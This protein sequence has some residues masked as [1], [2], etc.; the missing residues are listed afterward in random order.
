MSI[1]NILIRPQMLE[2]RPGDEGAQAL[3]LLTGLMSRLIEDFARNGDASR[4]VFGALRAEALAFTAQFAPRLS[5]TREHV[6][7]WLRPYTDVLEAVAGLEANSAEDILPVVDKLLELAEVLLADLHSARIAERLNAL[8][9]VVET[10]LGIGTATFETFFTACFDRVSGDLA[11]DFLQGAQTDIA[12]NHFALSRQLLALRRMLR[13]F[14]ADAPIPAFNRR[15][16]IRDLQLQLAAGDWDKNLDQIR[17]KLTNGKT[18]LADLLPTLGDT[19]SLGGSR[20]SRRAR[21]VAEPGQYSWYGSWF[22]GD[23]QAVCDRFDLAPEPFI[24]DVRLDP[25]PLGF[26]EHWAHITFVLD[27]AARALL[28]GLQMENGNRITPALNMGWQ[29]GTGLSSLLA[30][31]VDGKEWAEYFKVKTHPGFRAGFDYG[32]TIAGSFEQW[33]GFR[34]WLWGTLMHDLGNLGAGSKWSIKAREFFLTL[35]T[36]INSESTGAQKNHEKIGGFTK[37][38]RMGGAYLGAVVIGRK[39]WYYGVFSGPFGISVLSI[40][41]GG[42]FAFAGEVIAWLL[43]GAVARRLS[44]RYW[45]FESDN[46]GDGVLEFLGDKNAFGSFLLWSYIEFYTTWGGFWEGKTDGGKFGLKAVPE[47]GGG[48]KH[49]DATFRGYPAK[50]RHTWGMLRTTFTRV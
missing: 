8:A 2:R 38:G 40:L 3:D 5:T 23:G 14:I 44:G 26:L 32:L 42:A 24:G 33:P 50:R 39:N 34:G 30:F 7:E 43:A 49:E 37:L 36:L 46:F 45:G 41:I 21:D 15:S 1:G 20:S 31:F 35:F 10:D 9:D 48:L 16:V 19:L 28:Y 11:R 47:A 12:V 17:E 29:I 22:T 27:E 18:Q 25:I 13:N 4:I 6:L